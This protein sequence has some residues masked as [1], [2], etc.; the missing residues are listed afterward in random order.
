MTKLQKRAPRIG[1]SRRLRSPS[2][3][4][5]RRR[6]QSATA[7]RARGRHI[8]QDD[9]EDISISPS[10]RSNLRQRRMS[11]N[12]VQ[13]VHEPTED[14][15]DSDSSSSAS[16]AEDGEQDDDEVDGEEMETHKTLSRS[17]ANVLKRSMEEAL[18]RFTERLKEA[19]T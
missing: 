17:A 13:S 6:S 8:R 11:P 10:V 4:P 16:S 1:T 19:E 15:N 18:R 7:I 3:A 12:N 14:P 5:N 9:A 2:I